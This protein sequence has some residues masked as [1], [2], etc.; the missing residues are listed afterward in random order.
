MKTQY[1]TQAKDH[2]GETL[3]STDNRR[4]EL[5]NKKKAKVTNNLEVWAVQE[6]YLLIVSVGTEVIFA[7]IWMGCFQ[8]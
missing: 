6:T 8:G 3:E 5:P 7:Q 4:K 1:V 2:I